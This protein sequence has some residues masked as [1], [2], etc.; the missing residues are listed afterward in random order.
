VTTLDGKVA[1]VTG[2]GRGIGREEALALAS[3]GARVVVNDLGGDRRGVG[4]DATPAQETAELIREMG[5]EAVVNGDDVSSWD[6]A[7]RLVGQ[8]IDTFG[9][10]NVLVNNAGILRDAMSFNTTEDDWDAVI[11]V[12]LKGHFAPTK[13]A[14][15]YWRAQSKAGA[16]V[17]GSIINTT[18]DSGLFSNAGQSAYDAAKAGIA[19]LTLC[20]AREL[21]R[22]G[23]RVNAIAPRARTRLTAT[24]GLTETPDEGTFDIMSP[25]NVAPVVAWLAGPGAAG[26]NGQVFAVGGGT[27]VWLSGWHQTGI[28]QR[29]SGWTVDDLI[30]QQGTLF[31]GGSSATPAHSIPGLDLGP[32]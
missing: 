17:Y 8:A 19:S 12:H 6:G 22:Y 23:V 31:A 13:F 28:L 21:E 29:D 11:R 18:S 9:D 10:L 3:Q 27:V 32:R 25:A 20:L 14:S 5:G 30:A 15:A 26:V 7:E 1:I 4:N 24:V 16:D 2:A